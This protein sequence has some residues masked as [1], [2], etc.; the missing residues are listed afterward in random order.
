MQGIISI[1][2]LLIFYLYVFTTISLCKISQTKVESFGLIY[3]FIN[4]IKFN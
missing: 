4:F 3:V 1:L 2:Y